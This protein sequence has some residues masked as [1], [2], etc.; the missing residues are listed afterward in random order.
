MFLRTAKYH[1]NRFHP[2]QEQAWL[3]YKAG[4]N[5]VLP[6]G[7]RSGKSD[8]V[9]ECLI[10]DVE[11]TGYPSLYVAK[12]QKQARRILWPKL[13]ERLRNEP[14][15]KPNESRLEYIYKKG[16]FISL[17][18]ADLKA[19][20]LAGGAYRVISC[21]E[22]ALWKKPEI[23]QQILTPM[24]ADYNGQFIDVSTKRG[25]NHFYKLHMAASLS[26][27]VFVNEATMFDNPYISES[28][29]KKIIDEYPGGEA[30]PLYRQEVLNEY[31]VFEGMVFAIDA[32]EY[33]E[34][35]WD[36]GELENSYHWRGMDHGFSP[37]PTACVWISYNERRGYFQIHNEYKQQKLLISQH[38]EI[39]N[40][41]ENRRFVDSYSDI[42]P[43]VIAEYEAV[44]L[45]LTPAS[46]TD[47]TARMLRIVNALRSGKLK[48]ASNCVELLDEM[49][50]YTWED[51]ESG[52]S[53]DH[54]IDAMNYGFN[55]L[56]IPFAP[57]V[58]AE[59]PRRTS[60]QNGQ[61]FGY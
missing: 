25:K 21:D 43:Q 55:N 39:I 20:D 42:D 14:H 60:Y 5:L 52:K 2:K 26:D 13:N 22:L 36:L 32:A 30:N 24:L 37:D 49:A 18:G 45:Q 47:K 54:L 17:K 19:D 53:N 9:T 38:A 12:S 29:R 28:G 51:C 56:E 61:D 46:K 1:A 35:R 11:D 4:L 40:K 58:E 50:S 48:I 23:R 59:E 16:P 34:K 27:K 10:E 8:L 6:W 41:S 31:V 57:I 15:W 44:G 7:R 3:A 33:T